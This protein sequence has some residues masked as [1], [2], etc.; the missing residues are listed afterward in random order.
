M[1]F[2]KPFLS[3]FAVFL[4][5]LLLGQSD[6]FKFGKPIVMDSS[7]NSS[8]E[9]T[10]PIMT[11]DGQGM[12]F[13]RTLSGENIGGLYGG[14]DVWYSDK[15]GDSFK[16]AENL[17]EINNHGNNVIVGVS[18]N[19]RRLYFLNQRTRKSKN[20]AGLSRSDYNLQAKAWNRPQPV[21][22][23][24]LEVLGEFY[25][26]FIDKNEQLALWSLPKKTNSDDCDL[27]VSFSS[28][29]GENWSR[30]IYMGDIINSENDEMSPFFDEK[31]N[32][33]FF[34]RN[35]KDNPADYD[36]YYTSKLSDSWTSWSKPINVKQLNSPKF[37]AY[38]YIDSL[39]NAYFSSNRNDSLSD[40]F[41][42]RVLT[43][44]SVTD[45]LPLD[46]DTTEMVSQTSKMAF[47][48]D[49]MNAESATKLNKSYTDSNQPIAPIIDTV[50]RLVGFDFDKSK[51][52][53]NHNNTLKRLSD[54]LIENPDLKLEITG[55]TDSTGPSAYNLILSENRAKAAVNY[56]LRNGISSSRIEAI[57]KG[58]ELP[59]AT[60]ST[61]EGRAKNRRV[62]IKLSQIK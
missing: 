9:E 10:N 50:Y 6:S 52:K 30:P 58:E 51:I 42:S 46:E 12:F 43:L 60:N 15:K 13:V 24:D 39:G 23:N 17:A 31:T 44:D 45:T 49:S 8:A 55:H 26:C 61:I 25:G 18:K 29:K 36:I 11:T 40:I 16:K 20:K 47:S 1:T 62:E 35:R 54:S 4:S 19:G 59:F 2:F 5:A 21:N 27:Y 14:Q 22:V 41:K 28:D 48:S 57:G 33:L 37:D 7:I 3:V 34:S 53:P 38:L 32:C 56:F